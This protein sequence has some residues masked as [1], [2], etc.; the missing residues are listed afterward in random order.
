[1]NKICFQMQGKSCMSGRTTRACNSGD[2]QGRKMKI[3]NQGIGGDMVYTPY[4]FIF[5]SF[6]PCRW[7]VIYPSHSKKEKVRVRHK[8]R[9]KEKRMKKEK[10]K[11]EEEG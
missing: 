2:P 10:N 8:S 4:T 6:V 9:K 11:R 7:F 1:M 5:L 3:R